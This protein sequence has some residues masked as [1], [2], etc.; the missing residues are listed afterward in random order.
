[1][2]GFTLTQRLF[3]RHK[4]TK[5]LMF[6]RPARTDLIY[7]KVLNPHPHKTLCHWH[8]QVYEPTIKFNSFNSNFS[9]LFA[10]FAWE[11]SKGVQ[12][13]QFEL[14]LKNQEVSFSFPTPLVNCILHLYPTIKLC[15]PS[16]AE[17]SNVTKISLHGY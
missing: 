16:S 1:M 6:E 5:P 9:F 12:L 10:A 14:Q 3:L 8:T 17:N 11:W 7:F 2:F 4:N 13:S 15:I